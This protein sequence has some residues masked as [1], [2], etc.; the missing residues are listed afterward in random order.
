M[1][2]FDGDIHVEG[3]ADLKFEQSIVR[4]YS[5]KVIATVKASPLKMGS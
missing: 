4:H 1:L 3:N 5:H 2:N